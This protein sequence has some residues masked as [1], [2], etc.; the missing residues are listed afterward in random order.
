MPETKKICPL[1]AIAASNDHGYAY[2][3][4]ENCGMWDEE[5][6]QCGILSMANALWASEAGMQLLLERGKW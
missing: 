3:Y 4:E 6:E 2:C 5:G 1:L